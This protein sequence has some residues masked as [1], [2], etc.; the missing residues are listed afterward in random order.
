M[1][2]VAVS[3]WPTY[4]N[5][6]LSSGLINTNNTTT[7]NVMLHMVCPSLPVSNVLRSS[8]QLKIL[9]RRILITCSVK[10]AAKCPR[11]TTR[12]SGMRW[13]CCSKQGAPRYPANPRRLFGIDKGEYMVHQPKVPLPPSNAIV[14]LLVLYVRH[15][16]FG[17]LAHHTL[18]IR[19]HLQSQIGSSPHVAVSLFHFPTALCCYF[20]A[21]VQI[22]ESD[23]SPQKYMPPPLVSII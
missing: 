17:P 20:G 22:S 7:T 14:V 18:R 5:P 2:A 9:P 3:T 11:L 13:R 16:R 21:N 8:R 19:S 10:A 6:P 23:S 1:A 15:Y 12:Q 4:R